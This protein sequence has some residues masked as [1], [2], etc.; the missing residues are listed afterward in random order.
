MTRSRQLSLAPGIHHDARPEVLLLNAV[1]QGVVLCRRPPVGPPSPRTWVESMGE[2]CR[3]LFFT[4]AH[5]T[6]C[7]FY[8]S[9]WLMMGSRGDNR[10]VGGHLLYVQGCRRWGELDQACDATTRPPPAAERGKEGAMGHDGPFGRKVRWGSFFCVFFSTLLSLSTHCN[11][12]GPNKSIL[13]QDGMMDGFNSHQLFCFGYGHFCWVLVAE[14]GWGGRLGP[15]PEQTR[16]GIGGTYRANNHARHTVP[17]RGRRQL[18]GR[19]CAI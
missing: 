6:L 17:C 9:W 13:Q 11:R 18:G 3:L 12:K 2:H 14:A 19:H 15:N 1:A 4:P 8:F 5:N 16:R 10:L 7:A